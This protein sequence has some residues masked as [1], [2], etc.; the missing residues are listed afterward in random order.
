LR[1]PLSGNEG[2]GVMDCLLLLCLRGGVEAVFADATVPSASMV[3]GAAATIC[4]RRWFIGSGCKSRSAMI[5]DFWQDD[6]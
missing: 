4:A 3:D 6:E 2:V 1:L 5:R